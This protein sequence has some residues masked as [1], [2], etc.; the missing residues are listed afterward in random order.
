MGVKLDPRQLLVRRAIVVAHKAH[1]LCSDAIAFWYRLITYM[2]QQGII[3]PKF[4]LLSRHTAE[5]SLDVYWA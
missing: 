1:T 5:G 3:S 4:Q 2:S